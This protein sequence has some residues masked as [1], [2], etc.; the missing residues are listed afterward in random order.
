MLQ[1]SW[2]CH[3]SLNATNGPCKPSL[4]KMPSRTLKPSKSIEKLGGTGEGAME[5]KIPK[6][7]RCTGR[8]VLLS[9]RS[10]VVVILVAHL[11]LYIHV[12]VLRA[13]QDTW[14][15]KLKNL[16]DIQLR[17][18][19][20]LKVRWE[21]P[22]IYMQIPHQHAQSAHHHHNAYKENFRQVSA[23]TGT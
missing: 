2:T 17:P 3:F 9:R 18:E 21:F 11:D 22:A 10:Y 8:L 13:T 14:R 1:L 20:E 6:Y 23:S 4:P 5:R 15:S 19:C 12:W 16:L 7:K